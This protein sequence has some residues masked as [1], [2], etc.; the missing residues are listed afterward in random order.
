[1]FWLFL[2]GLDPSVCTDEIV[3]YLKDLNDSADYLCEILNSRYNTY[4]S[5]KVAVPFVLADE[6]MH[7][8]LWPHGCIAG[9]YR[10]PRYV[11]T[12]ARPMN[13]GSTSEE[14]DGGSFFNAGKFCPAKS[15]TIMDR[16]TQV[17]GGSV[18]FFNVVHWN[19]QGIL[20]KIDDLYV[21]YEE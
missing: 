5:F 12:R 20:N 11:P 4:S 3:K 6:L 13:S 17:L 16:P 18:N 1:M 2:S 21:K 9:K 14:F 8:N 7:P 19:V 15:I 10:A